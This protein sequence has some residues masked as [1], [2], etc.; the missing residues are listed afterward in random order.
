MGLFLR[1]WI[2][3]ITVYEINLFYKLAILLWS[4]VVGSFGLGENHWETG[5][6]HW[7]TV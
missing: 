5:E 7:E 4:G 2:L 6:N 3:S 1:F